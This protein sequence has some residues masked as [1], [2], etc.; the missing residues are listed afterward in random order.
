MTASATRRVPAATT[1]DPATAADAG[2]ARRRAP[3]DDDTTPVM[4]EVAGSVPVR[5]VDPAAPWLP[6][7]R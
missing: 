2:P 1:T 6:R 5:W 4:P 7:R 3:T